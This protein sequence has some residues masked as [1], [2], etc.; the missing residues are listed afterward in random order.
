M[1]VDICLT[2]KRV[3]RLKSEVSYE[4]GR[5]EE[6]V[7]KCSNNPDYYYPPTHTRTFCNYPYLALSPQEIQETRRAR[8]AT[9]VYRGGIGIPVEKYLLPL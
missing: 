1:W 4:A 9:E 6:S 7:E 5:A 8:N 2:A 3:S